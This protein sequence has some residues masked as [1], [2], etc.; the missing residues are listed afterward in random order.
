[1]AGNRNSDQSLVHLKQLPGASRQWDR[2]TYLDGTALQSPFA[3]TENLSFDRWRQASG[4]DAASTHA[5]GRRPATIVRVR[6][7]Q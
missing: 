3:L 2:N 6:P 5:T 1:M 7:N 4:L